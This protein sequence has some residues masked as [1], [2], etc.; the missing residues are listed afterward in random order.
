MPKKLLVGGFRRDENIPQFNNDFMKNYYEDPY[1][2]YFL[3]PDVR[4][5]RNSLE[6]KNDLPFLSQ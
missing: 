6:L 4:H 5:P 1:E 3:E 2:K